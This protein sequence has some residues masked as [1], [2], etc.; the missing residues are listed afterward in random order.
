MFLVM[1]ILEKT[2][3]EFNMKSE[4]YLKINNIK[5]GYGKKEVLFGVSM[6]IE[7]GK[8]TSIIGPNGAGKSTILKTIMGI[9][10]LN[11]G[12]IFFQSREISRKSI[13][14]RHGFIAE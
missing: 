8:I 4:P 14:Y 12:E 10:D 13:Q 3:W 6:E 2:M 7:E 1:R 5:A 11:E 9:I